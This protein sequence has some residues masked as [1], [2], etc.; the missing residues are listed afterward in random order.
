MKGTWSQQS[1]PSASAKKATDVTISVKNI[2]YLRIKSQAM[3]GALNQ[4]RL[5][6]AESENSA[7]P[8][9]SELVIPTATQDNPMSS[10]VVDT[11]LRRSSRLASARVKYLYFHGTGIKA[12]RDALL[13]GRA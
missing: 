5:D 6:I 1:R 12:Y 4:L 8:Q 10:L 11:A 9:V 3:P 13:T 2:V 7:G